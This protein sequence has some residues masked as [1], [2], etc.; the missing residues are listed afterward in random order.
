M[1]NIELLEEVKRLKTIADIGLLYSKNNYDKERYTELQEISFK[2]LSHTT[3]NDIEA[4]KFSFPAA[5]DYP[6]AKVDIRGLVLSPE[7]KVLLVKESIDGKWSLPGGWADIGCSPKETVVKEFKEETGLEVTAKALLAVFDKRF[8]DHPP[9][10]F[11]VYKMVFYCEPTSFE[12]TKGFD[13]LDVQYFAIHNLPE[14]SEDRIL[15]TQ[16]ELVY[17]KVLSSDFQAYFD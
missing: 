10:P 15:K 14:L 12:L 6:T 2:L 17:Q 1:T 5:A 4:L 8:H 11:Y 16:I 3:G 13:V 9:Q 7:K